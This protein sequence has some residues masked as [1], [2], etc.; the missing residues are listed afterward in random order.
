[1]PI[2]YPVIPQAVY[3]ATDKPTTI[4]A[5]MWNQYFDYINAGADDFDVVPM[6]RS[7]TDII[8]WDSDSQTFEPSTI[9]IFNATIWQEATVGGA[10]TEWSVS[11]ITGALGGVPADFERMFTPSGVPTFPNNPITFVT[12]GAN[13]SW[14][15]GTAKTKWVYIVLPVIDKLAYLETLDGPVVRAW[16]MDQTMRISN[17]VSPVAAMTFLNLSVYPSINPVTTWQWDILDA[18]TDA[19]I[20]PGSA[21]TLRSGSHMGYPDNLINS[22]QWDTDSDTDHWNGTYTLITSAFIEI[23][24][25]DTA[26]CWRNQGTSTG[27]TMPSS[28]IDYDTFELVLDVT[29]PSDLVTV[30]AIG[31]YTTTLLSNDMLDAELMIFELNPTIGDFRIE[32]T[33]DVGSAQA[34]QLAGMSYRWTYQEA[35]DKLEL[36]FATEGAYIIRQTATVPTWI[37]QSNTFDIPIRIDPAFDDVHLPNGGLITRPNSVTISDGFEIVTDTEWPV[38]I[39]NGKRYIQVKWGD[40]GTD[41]DVTITGNLDDPDD[42]EQELKP[43]AGFKFYKLVSSILTEDRTGDYIYFPNLAT[44]CKVVG[45]QSLINYIEVPMSYF[46]VSGPWPSQ[47]VAFTISA[48]GERAHVELTWTVDGNTYFRRKVVSR[49]REA[50]A[51]TYTRFYDV[52]ADVGLVASVTMATGIDYAAKVVNTVAFSPAVEAP[53]APGT[54]TMF[55]TTYGLVVSLEQVTGAVGYMCKAYEKWGTITNAV[56]TLF[57]DR[58]EG[59]TVLFPI[60][61]DNGRTM[62]VEVFSIGEGNLLSSATLGSGTGGSLTIDDAGFTHQVGTFTIEEDVTKWITPDTDRMKLG[63]VALDSNIHITSLQIQV[64]YMTGGAATIGGAAISS[65]ITANAG[66][67][68]ILSTDHGLSDD[69]LVTIRGTLNYNGEDYVVEVVDDNNFTIAAV[70]VSDESSGTWQ[71]AQ[72]TAGYPLSISVP[73]ISESVALWP[74]IYEPSSIIMPTDLYVPAGE[75]III[76]M[77]DTDWSSKGYWPANSAGEYTKFSV[78]FGYDRNVTIEKQND[79]PVY[80]KPSYLVESV[81]SA[82]PPEAPTE[83]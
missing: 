64:M 61:C 26:T 37:P 28:P 10:I 3:L 75:E 1:M 20:L 54:I 2:T 79:L 63:V 16:T 51:S 69:N 72:V 44:P 14:N 25:A 66:R 62:N 65:I 81:A 60:N 48:A 77:W 52:P 83:R 71:Q 15:D 53:A 70:Y 59:N 21:F 38:P 17:T 67:I 18:E 46:G 19:Q 7:D 27:F 12:V 40:E 82:A 36:D 68:N 32:I 35:T 39:E 56:Q 30:K 6:L 24:V 42:K 8:W 49:T 58:P 57:I 33:N 47:N 50:I 34:I 74:Q 11:G 80:K 9:N 55:G 4:T 78:A 13:L 73:G 31:N 22:L 23:A 76:S 45:Y 29:V 41:G 43:R 5:Q